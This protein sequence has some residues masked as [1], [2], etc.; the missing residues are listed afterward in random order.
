MHLD[1]DDLTEHFGASRFPY[2]TQALPVNVL[3]DTLIRPNGETEESEQSTCVSWK[4]ES[5]SAVPHIVL[6]SARCAGGQWVENPVKASW[7]IGTLSY[8]NMLSLPGYSFAQ[9]YWKIHGRVLPAYL[10]P[11]RKSVAGYF[12]AYPFQVGIDDT[13]RC[14]ENLSGIRRTEDGFYIASHGIKCKH[15]VLASGIFSELIPARPLLRPLLN[16]P[17]SPM[18]TRQEPLLVV[19]SGFSAADVIISTPPSQKIIH[20]FKWAPSTS[21]SPLRACHQQAYPEYASVYRQMKLAALD[22]QASKGRR[23][24]TSRTA[25]TRDWASNHEGYPNTEIVDVRMQR[26]MAIVTLRKNGGS[27]VERTISGFAYVIGRRGSL[28]Y[29]DKALRDEVWEPADDNEMLSGQS[30]REKALED[31]EVAPGVFII[32]SLTGDSLIRFAFGSCTYTAGKLM[33][34]DKSA[35]VNGCGMTS[36]ISSK[37]NSPLLKTMNGLDGHNDSCQPFTAAI[38]GPLDRRKENE[39]PSRA[40][41]AG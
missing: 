1:I 34:S 39:P 26:D 38:D 22:S 12:A 11:S 5:S 17:A 25:S 7:D 16:L 28:S 23:P 13:V 8:A 30:L 20:I 27:L 14:G 18:E 15:L 41:S 24:K 33:A 10:R 21:P 2:S 37:T 6:G 32:G 29:L 3:L 36:R 40:A 19:G 9:H 4:H 35:V 31:L